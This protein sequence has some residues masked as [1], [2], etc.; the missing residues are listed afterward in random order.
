MEPVAGVPKGR[1]ETLTITGAEA[2]DGNREVMDSNV[3]HENTPQQTSDAGCHHTDDPR[4]L[5]S[6]VA[7][8]RTGTEARFVRGCQ[9]PAAGRAKRREAAGSISAADAAPRTGRRR[10]GA[11]GRTTFAIPATFWVGAGIDVKSVQAWMGDTSAELTLNLYGRHMGTDADR[12][13]IVQLNSALATTAGTLTGPSPAA[14][15]SQSA[16]SA[17]LQPADLGESRE[18]ES[19]IER[20]TYALREGS[21]IFRLGQSGRS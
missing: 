10:V 14:S 5:N 20:L 15:A 19:G 9:G 2:V 7:V 6:S 4:P 8:H 13:G 21:R 11:G 16:P 18:P 17:P 12:S 1:L 3:W